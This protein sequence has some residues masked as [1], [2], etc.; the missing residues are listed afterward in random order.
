MRSLFF[1]ICFFCQILV[2]LFCIGCVSDTGTPDSVRL[3][4]FKEK[5]NESQEYYDAWV[6]SDPDN[7]EAWG[8]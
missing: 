5:V 1:K 2:I 3:S 6:A 4:Q 8:A 7:A